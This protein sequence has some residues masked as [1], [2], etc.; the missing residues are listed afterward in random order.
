MIN[1]KTNDGNIEIGIKGDLPTLV[2][3]TSLIVF[4]VYEGI[5]EHNAAMAKIFKMY[6]CERGN[7]IFD[8]DDED[9]KIIKKEPKT[10]RGDMMDMLINHLDELSAKL[11]AEKAK[12]EDK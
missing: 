7:T 8:V 12:K 4:S 10:S 3:D 5:M 2:A 11:K 6:F 9:V 1:V